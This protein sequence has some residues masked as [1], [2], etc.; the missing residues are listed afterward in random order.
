MKKKQGIV[1][2]ISNSVN[3]RTYIGST[4]EYDKRYTL[5]LQNCYAGRP[6]DLVE[7]M[8]KH[9]SDKFYI[10]PIEQVEYNDIKEL[11][12]IENKWIQI[13]STIKYGYNMMQSINDRYG[14]NNERPQT[15]IYRKCKKDPEYKMYQKLIKIYKGR[16]KKVRADPPE[17]VRRE[18]LCTWMIEQY[19]KKWQ[20]DKKYNLSLDRIERI[21]KYAYSMFF[22]FGLEIKEI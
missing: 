18:E 2:R 12:R 4:T 13:F 8:E 10:E 19:K 7:A 1:Y 16:S 20:Y 17:Y 3:Y 22:M 21:I 6:T 14:N 11:R 9:G 15:Y 5:H